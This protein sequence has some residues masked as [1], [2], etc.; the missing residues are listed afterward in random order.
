MPFDNAWAADCEKFVGKSFDTEYKIAMT[1]LLQIISEETTDSGNFELTNSGGYGIMPDYVGRNPN[2]AEQRRGF[3]NV[4]YTKEKRLD[5]VIDYKTA[6]IDKMGEC[7]KAG[8]RLAKSAQATVAE[9][10]LQM[11][12]NAFNPAYVGGDG[13]P[14]A[15][16]D[17]PVASMGSE[18][19]KYIPDPESGTFSNL[20]TDAFSVQAITSAQSKVGHFMTPDGLQFSANLDTVIIPP[21][22]EEKAKR[23]FGENANL[24][25]E[26]NNNDA[27]PVQGMGYIVLKGGT[28]N[29]FTG[30]QWAV[31]DRELMKMV[32]AIVYTTKPMVVEQTATDKFWRQF[33]AYMDLGVGWG[34]ARQIYFNNPA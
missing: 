26:T 23:F 4:V 22:L 27:N 17:H 29:A 2:Y 6:K 1:P 15:A 18:G 30:K 25:P 13:K 21:E 3:N 5:A 16:T 8:K 11:F 24:L 7:A 33:T 19:R 9:L 20:G 31:C 32:C 14:F 34:D 10:V 28:G 12:R